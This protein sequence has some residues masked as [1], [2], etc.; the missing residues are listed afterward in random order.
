MDCDVI[1][2]GE[3]DSTL[4]ISLD[5]IRVFNIAEFYLKSRQERLDPNREIER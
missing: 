3:E 1:R 4:R 2:D 5:A